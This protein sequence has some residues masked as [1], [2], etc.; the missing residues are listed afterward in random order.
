MIFYFSGTGNSYYVAEKT[1]GRLGERLVSI[2]SEMSGGKKEFWYDL[3]DDE[4]IGFVFP[5]YAWAPPKMVV[6][7]IESLRLSDARGY[8]VFAA[9]VCG[10]EAG[11]SVKLLFRRQGSD[12]TALF[13]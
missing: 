12:W 1:A 2:S 10:D 11:N 8:Y 3:Q 6:E 13:P 9:A 5:V 4:V 7:F